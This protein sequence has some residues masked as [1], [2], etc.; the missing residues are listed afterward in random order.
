L[1]GGETGWQIVD[2][3]GNIFR[4]GYSTNTRER[5]KIVSTET[6]NYDYSKEILYVSTWYLDEI[7]PFGENPANSIKFTYVTSG[8]FVNE[9]ITY[10]GTFHVDC[11]FNPSTIVEK[12][13]K[14]RNATEYRYISSITTPK[15]SAFFE[16][17]FDREDALGL[18]RLTNIRYQTAASGVLA[19]YKFRISYSNSGDSFFKNNR[20]NNLNPACNMPE[21]KRLMLDT[22]YTVAG[23]NKK[24]VRAFEYTNNKT[25]HPQYGYDMYELPPRKSWYVDWAGYFN[26]G[27]HHGTKY[28]KF[29]WFTD[30]TYTYTNGMDK[31]SVDATKSNAL[32]K[33]YLPTGGYIKLEYGIKQRG[34]LR[35]NQL[36][37]H[38]EQG[39]M[40][41]G[42]QYEY[43]FF[44][45]LGSPVSHIINN[46]THINC[47]GST[48]P[49][50]PQYKMY[51]YS[52]TPQLETS[53]FNGGYVSVSEV[54]LLGNGKVEHH[55]LDLS[56]RE[57]PEA[58]K[59][60]LNVVIVN[61]NSSSG[62][63]P[64]ATVP[65]GLSSVLYHDLGA[66]YLTKIYKKEGTSFVLTQEVTRNFMK[67]TPV[68]LSRKNYRIQDL[69]TFNNNDFEYRT[70]ILGEYDVIFR[71]VWLMSETSKHYENGQFMTSNT[72]YEYH[73]IYKSFPYRI[74]NVFTDGTIS[75]QTNRF[76]IDVVLWTDLVSETTIELKALHDMLSVGAIGIPI[77]VLYQQQLPGQSSLNFVGGSFTH[78]RSYN[79]YIKPFEAYHAIFNQPVASFTQ[80]Q[81]VSNTTL[82]FDT[83]YEL[84]QRFNTYDIKGLLTLSTDK[85]GIG[86][87]YNYDSFG[88]LV[89]STVLGRT[90][91]TVLD[92]RF[93]VIE[94][95]D[96]NGRKEYYE[97]DAFNQLR[98][99][100]DHDNNII[101]RSRTHFK[102]EDIS[103]TTNLSFSGLNKPNQII[104]MS[105]DNTQAFYG[106]TRFIWDFGN[107]VTDETEEPYVTFSYPATGTYQTS[108]T[109]I[110]P[111]YPEPLHY[112]KP[113]TILN[114]NMVP[115]ICVSHL[116]WDYCTNTPGNLSPCNTSFSF[117]VTAKV[118]DYNNGAYGLEN[119]F[120]YQW[121]ISLDGNNWTSFGENQSELS[122]PNEVLWNPGTHYIKCE[123]SD[124]YAVYTSN[125]ALFT[126]TSNCSGGGGIH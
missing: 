68:I 69:E 98:L 16:Y 25:F 118:T 39:T 40:I 90:S 12:T 87:N 116:S 36:S 123:M 61:G 15:M 10:T 34:G 82:H 9:D 53:G 11:N 49:S 4:F 126:I 80:L 64:S 120:N 125:S 95:T 42:T 108:V 71:P 119:T 85:D 104:T 29:A 103:P 14:T 124:G 63:L 115:Q 78:F 7:I 8:Y 37:S 44:S 43:G 111:E 70:C 117:S 84:N 47:V 58:I 54:D 76:P 2:A 41:S 59:S 113:V 79:N 13:V 1:A 22:I 121:Y 101:S 55:F 65:V 6:A 28:N 109:L 17:V 75:R 38:N 5:T 3:M 97:Y 60:K 19:N 92:N 66:E 99:I 83:R 30:G 77:E 27:T 96:V 107:G 56:Q 88:N 26:G 106:P 62:N 114:N 89:S 105:T 91:S 32:A 52:I 20:Y 100:Q 74:T 31:S 73:S 67:E 51:N 110:N 72:N 57:M 81:P 35:I 21:C 48:P 50:R 23:N 122:L 45:S 46:P 112:K 86:T 94:K 102:T 18:G 24:L 93:N 33:V